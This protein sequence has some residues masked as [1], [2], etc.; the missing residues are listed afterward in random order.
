MYRVEC[1]VNNRSV[2]NDSYQL[3]RFRQSYRD[4]VEEAKAAERSQR[5]LILQRVQNF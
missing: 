2:K 5:D 3:Q 4:S 1:I